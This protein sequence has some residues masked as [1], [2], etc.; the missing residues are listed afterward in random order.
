SHGRC[1][2]EPAVR[3]A[4]GAASNSSSATPAKLVEWRRRSRSLSK[5]HRLYFLPLPHGQGS[6][7]PIRLTERRIVEPAAIVRSPCPAN[8]SRMDLPGM[9]ANLFSNVLTAASAFFHAASGAR[10]GFD[11]RIRAARP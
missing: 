7:R 11:L 2:K 4:S 8:T 6:L 5:Q 9:P 1:S 10:Y 3:W